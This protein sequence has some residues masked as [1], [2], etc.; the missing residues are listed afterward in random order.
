MKIS[1]KV[2]VALIILLIITIS[3]FA[4]LGYGIAKKS[5]GN[6]TSIILGNE[7]KIISD[8]LQNWMKRNVAILET[9]SAG[10]AT[11][12]LD[13]HEV[14]NK[15]LAVFGEDSGIFAIYF[16]LTDN[17]V[18]SSD[19]WTPDEG[20]DLTTRDY[21]IEAIKKDGAFLSEVYIDADSKDSIITIAIPLKSSAGNVAGV[22]AM[23]VKLST[24]FEFMNG[25]KSFGGAGKIY[26]VS[27]SNK[28]LYS[29]MNDTLDASVSDDVMLVDSYDNMIK[30]IGEIVHQDIDKVDYSMFLSVIPDANWNIVMAVDNAVIYKGAFAI[31]NSFLMIAVV[32]MIIGILFT[33]VLNKKL[34]VKFSDIEKYIYEIAHYRL[35]Y[36]PQRDYRNSNDEIGKIWNSI[37]MMTDNLRSLAVNINELSNNTAITSKDVTDNVR[38]TAVFSKEVAG[39]VTDIAHTITNQAEDT[40][41]TTHVIQQNTEAIDN[42]IVILGDLK[43]AID[44]INDKK[45]EGKNALDNLKALMDKSKIET[46]Y[47][48]ETILDTDKSVEAIFKASEM[49]Q[50][51]SDQ[52]NLL[53]LNA[54][55]EAARAGEAGKGFAV[56]ADE[57]RKLAENS[58]KFTDEIRD[59]IEKLKEKSQIAVDKMV[60]VGELVDDQD[61]ATKVTE[62]KFNDIEVA[63]VTSKD[64]VDTI[65]ENSKSIGEKNSFII[66]SVQQFSSV[67]EENVA[68]TEEAS[69]NVEMQSTAIEEILSS[70]EK[71]MEIAT[72]LQSEAGVF[73]I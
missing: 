3:T 54:A 37:I 43:S 26:L 1:H 17:T 52:T 45:Q 12:H 39:A 67:G 46:A 58:S 69:A 34:N 40:A 60:Q 22:I 72:Q 28:I 38:D 48:N 13:F 55:I 4:I 50:E 16:I 27:P 9:V 25:F 49:I 61:L 18:I 70:C 21:Y 5:E 71:L 68:T 15:E 14:D 31:R 65:H 11:N 47:V 29:N 19:Y 56:V 64:I 36:V 41:K 51:I 30:N 35:N 33:I 53:A 42:M 59:I 57:I 2:S 24:F 73:K 20:D 66:Q 32:L 7:S 62:D 10:I 8:E 63:V 23:D 44:D 6:K